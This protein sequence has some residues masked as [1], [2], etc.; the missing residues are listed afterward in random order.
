MFLQQLTWDV[1]TRSSRGAEAH[2]GIM[3]GTW[4]WE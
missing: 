3:E 2:R 1:I 4:A